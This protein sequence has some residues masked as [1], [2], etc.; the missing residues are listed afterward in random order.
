MMGKLG[1]I[2]TDLTIAD[3]TA[4]LEQLSKVNS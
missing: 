4:K 3:Q 1:H 2:I